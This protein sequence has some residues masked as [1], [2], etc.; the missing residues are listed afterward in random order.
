MPADGLAEA[1]VVAQAEARDDRQALRLRQLAA[2]QH[3]ADAR[4]IDGDRL[5]GEDVLAGLDRG[6]EMQRPEVRRR[7]EQHHVDTAVDEL[8]VGVEADEAVVGRRRRPCEPTFSSCLRMCQALLA[9]RSS[10]ASAMAT[11]LTF[12]VGGERLGGRAGAPVAAADQPDPQQDR[13]RPR[14]DLG[15]A[16]RVP[17]TDACLEEIRAGTLILDA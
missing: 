6:P 15:S 5:L 4:G 12:G 9:S 17:A 2:L 13:C 3:R 10:K 16:A 1:V 8:L 7:A 11:S 14:A